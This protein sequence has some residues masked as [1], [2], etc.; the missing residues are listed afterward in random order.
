MWFKHRDK[1]LADSV[2]GS[3]F[4]YHVLLA[5]RASNAVETR[6]KQREDILTLSPAEILCSTWLL[7]QD[8]NV[9]WRFGVEC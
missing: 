8:R 4:V 5:V 2:I 7:M 1:R 9:M 3:S 6:V